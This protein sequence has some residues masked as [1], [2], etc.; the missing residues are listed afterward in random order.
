MRVT[1]GVK[2]LIL[3]IVIAAAALRLFN[4]FHIPF[5]G[6]ELT[7]LLTANSISFSDLIQNVVRTNS[8]PA[9]IQVL[10]FY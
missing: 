1:P 3:A 2:I 6:D 10:L 5:T 4:L 7:F 9:G 8:N